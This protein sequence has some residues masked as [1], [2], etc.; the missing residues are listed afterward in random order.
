MIGIDGASRLH[1]LFLAA[2]AEASNNGTDTALPLV[3]SSGPPSSDMSGGC[4][5][6]SI[7]PEGFERPKLIGSSV[8]SV[9]NVWLR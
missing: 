5:M 9:G 6:R 3:G 7:S 4:A 2:L 1:G 8:E